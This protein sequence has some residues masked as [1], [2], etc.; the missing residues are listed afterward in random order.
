M[1]NP[2]DKTVISGEPVPRTITRLGRYTLKQRLGVGGMAE[3]YLAEQDGPKMFTKK[4]VIKRILPSLA[5]DAGFV[6]MFVREAQVAARLT[7]TNVV[8]IYELGEQKNDDGT[9]EYFI[10][11]EYIDG[12]T[13]QRLASASWAKG[14]AVPVEVVL[15]TCAD[16][17]RGL[18]AAHTLVNDDGKSLG[19]VHRD[20]SP[21][22]MMVSKEGVTKVLDFGIAKGPDLDGPKTR[23]GQLRGK[24]PYMSPEQI[25]GHALD[26]RTDLW[27]LGV[28]I[29]WLL[30][31]ERPFDRGTDYHTMAAILAD[32][33]K[34]PSS[35]NPGVPA[36]LEHIILALLEKDPTK[37]PS[38]GADVADI[39][40]ELT[41]A[42][43]GTGRRPTVSFVEKFL[44]NAVPAG[45]PLS[46]AGDKTS[47]TR[48]LG[49]VSNAAID[50][51][52][53]GGAPRKVTMPAEA[54]LA[55]APSLT[56]AAATEAVSSPPSTAGAPISGEKTAEA[57]PDAKL[58]R[59]TRR[60]GNVPE[61]AQIISLASLGDPVTAIAPDA[62]LVAPA[63]AT[64]GTPAQAQAR[65]AETGIV[66]ALQAA[67]ANEAAARENAGKSDGVTAKANHP[68]VD[69]LAPPREKSAL[70][71]IL[72]VGGVLVLLLGGGAF[73]VYKIMQSMKGDGVVDAGVVV[74]I[75]DA[76]LRRAD[77][78][79]VV[80]ARVDAGFLVIA[81]PIVDAGTLAVKPPVVD[82][83][84]IAVKPP[85]VDAGTVV[86]A[87]VNWT[88]RAKAPTRIEW[89]TESGALVGRGSGTFTLPKGLTRLVAADP[90]RRTEHLLSLTGGGASKSVDYNSLPMSTL[91]PKHVEGVRIYIERDYI[92]E[93]GPVAVVAGTYEVRV[94]KGT[95]TLMKKSIEFKAGATVTVDAAN[96][97]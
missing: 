95:K 94:T 25:Q 38:S 88:V 14:Q 71:A 17:A 43:T 78:G 80:A 90:T 56:S 40:E 68:V 28:S 37:R 84:T 45:N 61:S 73:G 97:K 34:P 47:A 36:G 46:E 58:P 74:A 67:K 10:A 89:R 91:M 48:P 59:D 7:H 30:C 22:N 62:P 50:L 42:G 13:L 51:S 79:S 55:P 70:P 63:P 92:K 39:L 69:M 52:A 27:A 93:S 54:S 77:A 1:T 76:G 82:A 72:A 21:D 5:Q 6:A 83:G 2:N 12:L 3:V 86:V 29:Y 9:V 33:P 66:N 23:T 18:H 4:V 96:P 53:E 16:A 8:Q 64:P 75:A 20:I 26:A 15:R 35:L 65:S 11:M 44:H 32:V 60:T 19:L 41:P 31:G 87:P 85:V 81:P 49:A 57:K 24:V